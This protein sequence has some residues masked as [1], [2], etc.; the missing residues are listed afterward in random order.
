MS[1][2]FSSNTMKDIRARGEADEEFKK[3]FSDCI[4]PAKELVK[5]LFGRIWVNG[6]KFKVSF[7]SI[8]HV[9]YL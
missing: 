8:P 5:E 2:F 7:L 3:Q 9:V 4:E 6:K 1:L